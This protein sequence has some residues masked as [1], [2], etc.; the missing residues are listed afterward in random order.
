[1][2]KV[3]LC[4][5]VFLFV[6]AAFLFG[7]GLYMNLYL[8]PS[9][10]P[11]NATVINCTS[12]LGDKIMNCDITVEFFIECPVTTN[13]QSQTSQINQNITLSNTKINQ[14]CELEANISYVGR[15]ETTGEYC[16]DIGSIITIFYKVSDPYYMSP[17]DISSQ[18]GTIMG[19]IGACVI[20]F[21]ILFLMLMF[22][23]DRE[24]SAK[25]YLMEP[26]N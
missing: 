6:I 11:V 5:A 24:K 2:N 14:T 18:N 4:I 3:V 15:V 17:T 20:F 23:Y 12:T 26:F 7:G 16:P 9:Y 19:T 25:Q 10:V 1:M 22:K 13:L 21:I 8:P